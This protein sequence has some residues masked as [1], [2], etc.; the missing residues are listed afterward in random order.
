MWPEI[1]RREL[2]PPFQIGDSLLVRKEPGG[3]LQER[4]VKVAEVATLSREPHSEGRAALDGQSLEELTLK[5][6]DQTA[7]PVPPIGNIV[8]LERRRHFDGIDPTI[9][10][11]ERDRV[12]RRLDPPPPWLVEDSTQLAQAPSQLATRITGNIPQQFT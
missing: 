10:E 12:G 2:Y 9:R 6:A 11:V 8:I 5:S 3:L 4:C 7:D 1:V